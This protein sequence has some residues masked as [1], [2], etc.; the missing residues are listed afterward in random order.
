[1]FPGG[2]GGSCFTLK[3]LGAFGTLRAH[4][5]PAEQLL[6]LLAGGVR[7]DPERAIVEVDTGIYR[8]IRSDLRIR[9]RAS[10]RH[11]HQRHRECDED[12]I[13]AKNSL[14]VHFSLH[15]FLVNMNLFFVILIKRRDQTARGLLR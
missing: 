4:D 8:P 3:S 5:I 12:T 15:F 6:I 1:L 11:Q 2:S 14:Q 13:F 9:P 10:G 7:D